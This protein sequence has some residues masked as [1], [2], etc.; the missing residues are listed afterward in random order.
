MNVLLL[1]SEHARYDEFGGMLGRCGFTVDVLDPCDARAR[2]VAGKPYALIL[3]DAV[4]PTAAHVAIRSVRRSS[5]APL[6]VLTQRDP[7]AERLEGL[8]QGVTEYLVKPCAPAD[9]VERAWALASGD[10]Y[11]KGGVVR[12]ADL[13]IDR[14]SGKAFRQGVDLSLSSTLFE[15]LDVLMA[16]R[17]QVLSRAE[18]IKTV[19][20]SSTSERDNLVTV[21]VLRL[22]QKLDD[23]FP[24]KLLHTVRGRGYVLKLFNDQVHVL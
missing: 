21:G 18:L 2:L 16:H 6:L 23:P 7:V 9:L 8:A 12:L 5:S 17:G 10:R 24:L 11:L 4:Q 14:A 3:V 13:A 22:R 19:W 1:K 15:L 20:G